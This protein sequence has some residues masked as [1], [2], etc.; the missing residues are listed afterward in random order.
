MHATLY[1]FSCNP[2][3]AHDATLYIDLLVQSYSLG[4]KQLLDAFWLF[5]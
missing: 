4:Q 5:E 3:H 2:R 1:I